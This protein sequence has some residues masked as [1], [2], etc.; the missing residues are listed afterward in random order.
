MLVPFGASAQQGK[1]IKTHAD[2]MCLAEHLPF[3]V[4]LFPMMQAVRIFTDYLNGD[5]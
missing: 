1:M 2:E 5:R 3:T 4:A